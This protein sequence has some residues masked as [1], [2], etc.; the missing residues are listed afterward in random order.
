MTMKLGDAH[1]ITLAERPALIAEIPGVL[2]GAWPRFMLEGRPGHGVDLTQLLTAF[3]AHQALLLT[4]TDDLLGVGL[5]LPMGWDQSTIRL[6]AGWDGAVTAAADFHRRGGGSPTMVCAL[7]ITMTPAGIGR[8]LAAQLIGAL[9]VAATRAGAAS[10][11][12]PVRPIHKSRHPLIP[13]DQYLTWRTAAGEMFDP[14]VRLHLR[15]GG[16]IAGITFPSMTIS[17]SIADWEG[18]TSLALP[19]SGEHLI[20]GG[21]VPLRVDRDADIGI[22][23]EPN[24]WI[25]HHTSAG[26]G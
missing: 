23:Q 6:P 7:S 16:M 14:W 9:K 11:I 22:Y 12:A 15:L 21:L 26:C 25:V 2:A 13:L 24:V 4:R 17:G 19:S 20:P 10:M 18:W 8:G 3:P 5:S 1:L